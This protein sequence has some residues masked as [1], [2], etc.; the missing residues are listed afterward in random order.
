MN[1]NEILQMKLLISGKVQGIGFRPYIAN[2]ACKN[3]LKG[4]VRNTL[5]GV[6][7]ILEGSRDSL[8][9][10][11]NHYRDNLPSNA[12]I[13]S[14]KIFVKF[15]NSENA[16]TGF[17]IDKS[18][19]ERIS[20]DSLKITPPADLA[21]CESCENEFNDKKSR[22][23]K[24]SLISCTECGPR[25]SIINDLPYDR[26]STTL[27]KWDI[28]EQ[29]LKEYNDPS[30]KRFHSQTINCKNCGPE[31][32]IY[33]KEESR[34]LRVDQFES[35]ESKSNFLINELFNGKILSL[36]GIGGFQLICDAKNSKAIQ[37][38]R[39]FKNRESQALA[40]MAKDLKTA[41][42]LIELDQ[43]SIKCLTSSVRPILI[44]EKKNTTLVDHQEIAPDT[45]TYGVML[46]STGLHKLLF[47]EHIKVLITTSANIKGE[48]IS[49]DL[50]EAIEQ[51]G[52]ISDYI[53]DINRDIENR[54]DDS[55]YKKLEHG[56]Q[57]W[58]SARGIAPKDYK[59]LT[60]ETTS[61]ILALGADL[62]STIS[63]S[64]QNLINTSPHL[65][66]L[67]DFESLNHYEN[68]LFNLLENK[69][70]KPDVIACDLHPN[71][72]TS[73]LAKNLSKNLNIP[74]VKVQHHISH[75]ATVMLEHSISECL[76]VSCDGTGYG[77]DGRLWGCEFFYL[78]K[79][80][81]LRLAT[82]ESSP[83]V[84]REKSIN[85]PY[86]QLLEY[87]TET[88]L[89]EKFPSN[90]EFINHQKELLEKLLKNSIRTTSLG[91][92]FDLVAA[93]T[94]ISPKPIEYQGQA[95][96]RLENE[97]WKYHHK[98]ENFDSND[99]DPY[100]Y[101]LSNHQ[102]LTIINKT[103]L[104][105]KILNDV[106]SGKSTEEISWKFHLTIALMLIETIQA[107]SIIERRYKTLPVTFSGGVFQNKLLRT[108]LDKL[109]K[110]RKFLFN[111]DIPP[112][113]GG[114]STG[115]TQW[116]SWIYEGRK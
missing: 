5:D 67:R 34:W 111:I 106:L 20:T 84:S 21:I 89:I 42:E 103:S 112:G 18:L 30:D 85:D 61:N 105:E 92:L 72:Q 90:E 96:I 41:E 1:K 28:C 80:H 23:Y 70:I 31:V 116:V 52:N 83:L 115:Q 9:D 32:I 64:D 63:Y 57:T 109:N 68:Y 25:F 87:L 62:K 53:V 51:L 19:K 102:G 74:L 48:P 47:S 66:S 81:H 59:L 15:V 91:R 55:I 113:D 79:G 77:E 29:C 3:N 8:E 73:E 86:Q 88:N 17:F 101:S 110:E 100:S 104:I 26:I 99:F 22:R 39:K 94:G 4:T 95:A 43:D 78:N 10:F 14:Q 44:S 98:L 36:K 65:G 7:I 114:I 49:S 24:Y 16:F 75:A 38:I 6:E 82:L 46:P 40:L 108:F 2:L 13:E 56:L 58:R 93:L 107:I 11:Q 35:D 50:N 12:K 71:Y 60:K 97:A 54:V 33:E 69:I 45:N 76:A 27:E 37:K